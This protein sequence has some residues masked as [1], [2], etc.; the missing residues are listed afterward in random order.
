MSGGRPAKQ[1]N[2][3]RRRRQR[4]RRGQGK[5]AWSERERSK[6]ARRRRKNGYLIRS[7]YFAGEINQDPSANKA[8]VEQR[9]LP[10]L[11]LP[12]TS[13]S[14]PAAVAGSVSLD[15]VSPDALQH[16]ARPDSLVGPGALVAAAVRPL[17]P[18]PLSRPPGA[19]GPANA[20]LP[21]RPCLI[22]PPRARLGPRWPAACSPPRSDAHSTAGPRISGGAAHAAW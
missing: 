9:P 17:R 16:H 1:L 8:G 20:K 12:S 21:P 14:P 15:D 4:S 5:R 22:P 19:P 18:V 2:H 13:P 10:L 11:S 7:G 6:A 3:R